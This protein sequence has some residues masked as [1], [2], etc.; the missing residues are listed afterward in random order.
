LMLVVLTLAIAAVTGFL[1]NRHEVTQ[2]LQEIVADEGQVVM[3]SRPRLLFKI[4][5]NATGGIS[6]YIAVQKTQGWGGPL[7]VATVMDTTGRIRKTVVLWQKETPSYFERMKRNHFFRQFKGKR[8]SEQFVVGKDIEAVSRATVSSEG[9][10]AAIRTGS[11][12]LGKEVLS[13]DIE[14]DTSRWKFGLNEGLLLLLYTI[15][16]TGFLKKYRK[17][18][19]VTLIGGLVFL[20]IYLNA[21]ISIANFSLV[22]LGYVPSIKTYL[23]WWLLIPGTLIITFI[24]EK[25]H[26]CY[27]LC[28]FGAT[29]EIL[30]KMGGFHVRLSR[31]I[32]N[33][34]AYIRYALTWLALTVIL[35]TMNPA[36]G[37][38]EPFATFFGLEGTGVQW[39]ILPVVI[40]GAFIFPR[41]WC[42]FFCP[43]MVIL[44]LVAK[45]KR[46]LKSKIVATPRNT[47]MRWIKDVSHEKHKNNT[48]RHTGHCAHRTDT[49]SGVDLS[50]PGVNSIGIVNWNI[51]EVF[52]VGMI[53]F[54]EGPAA[55]ANFPW[56]DNWEVFE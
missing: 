28:P 3:I 6:G 51:C 53:G 39:Y 46:Q 1:R 50:C 24:L 34:A 32:L 14:D 49:G 21:S 29:Q 19:W 44:N 55:T 15:T 17:L 9:F 43:V 27:W 41:F 16:L 52:E 22:L 18:R 2:K 54:S 13:L 37:A 47:N 26:Y 36:L 48:E 33:S 7:S 40:L 4:S 8:V 25:N 5:D 11:H 35:L 23:F 20:G 42:H 10:T 30:A 12:D 31:S 38:Y 45:S 56:L